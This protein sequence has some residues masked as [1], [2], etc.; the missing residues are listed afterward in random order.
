M[1]FY[2]LHTLFCTQTRIG[3]LKILTHLFCICPRYQ[4]DPYRGLELPMLKSLAY[5]VVG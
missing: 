2:F 1:A 4:E 3:G 5:N